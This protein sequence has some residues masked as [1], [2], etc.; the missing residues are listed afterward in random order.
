MNAELTGKRALVTGAAQGLGRAVA[1]RLVDLGAEVVIADV[2]GADPTAEE[3][4][5]RGVQ[6][7]VSDESDVAAA[8]AYAA[9][10]LGGLDIL[11]NNA[12]IERVAPL[13]AMTKADFD[14]TMAVN[15]GGVFLCSKHAIPALADGGGVIVNLSST[16]G[17]KGSPLLGAYSASKSAV[18]RLTETLAIELRDAGIRVNAICPGSAATTM[19]TRIGDEFERTVGLSLQTHIDRTQGGRLVE[20]SEVADLVAFLVSDRATAITGSTNVVDLG[21]SASSV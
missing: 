4:G 16:I 5:C 10:E 1:K 14:R 11:V 8:I 2:S 18:L 19:M 6:C 3:L 20:P 21:A 12:G 13:A 15:V 9:G 17:L 7:D